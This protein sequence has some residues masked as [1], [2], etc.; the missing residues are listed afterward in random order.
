MA[1][2]STS[3]AIGPEATSAGST[4]VAGAVSP[5]L[6]KKISKVG[7]MINDAKTVAKKRQMTIR[8]S[9]VM[10]KGCKTVAKKKS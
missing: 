6:G 8:T 3:H 2:A 9:R 1:L 4:N 10:I 7:I 5:R